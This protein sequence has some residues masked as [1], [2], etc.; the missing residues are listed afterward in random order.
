MSFNYI[1]SVDIVGVVNA[2]VKTL[3]HLTELMHHEDQLKAKLREI[4]EPVPH[5]NLLPMDV[6]AHIKLKNAEQSI[7]MQTYQCPCKFHEAWGTL[8]QK[9]LDAG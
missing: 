5:V 1:K 9:H 8:I 7:K 3:T 2:C 6:E 4:F